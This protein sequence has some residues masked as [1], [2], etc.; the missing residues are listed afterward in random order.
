MKFNVMAILLVILC[1]L[2]SSTFCRVISIDQHPTNYIMDKTNI[3]DILGQKSNNV[4]LKEN[5]H[6]IKDF[7]PS[8]VPK[9][10]ITDHCLAVVQT[11]ANDAKRF[12]GTQAAITLYKPEVRP[13]QWSS[14]RMKLSNGGDSIEAGWMVNP[15]LFKDNEAHLYTKYI[16]GGKECINT[17]CPGFTVVDTRVPLGYIPKTYSQVNGD[18]W[19]W[20]ITIKK[21]QDDGNWWLSAITRNAGEIGIGYWPKSLFSSPLAEVANQVQ[22]GGEISNPEKSYRQPEMGSGLVGDYNTK[23]SAYFQQVTIVNE[24][25]QSGHPVD[26]E[27]NADCFPYYITRDRGSHD[28]D[29]PNWGRVIFF[30]GTRLE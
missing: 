4:G 15:D 21:H 22:W 28:D 2:F 27:K 16:A 30:G 14:A 23:H 8:P 29:D 7:D 11:R 3:D 20:N 13:K 19:V 10:I 9:P 1:S 24:S 17:F 12:F 25:F 6:T 5:G 26:T 18:Q